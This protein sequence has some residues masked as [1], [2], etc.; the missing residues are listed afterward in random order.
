MTRYSTKWI[1]VHPEKVSKLFKA[2]SKLIIDKASE[3]PQTI[4]FKNLDFMISELS[5][6][7]SWKVQKN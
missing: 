6:Y 2:V 4:T 5:N 1:R 3:S 7:D